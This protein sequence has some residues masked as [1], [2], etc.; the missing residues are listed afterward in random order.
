MLSSTSSSEQAVH[1]GRIS[2]AT[3]GL[4]GLGLLYFLGVECM[5]RFGVPRISRIEKRTALEYD[6]AIDAGGDHTSRKKVLVVGNSLL[7]FGVR[8]DELHVALS[9]YA[10]VRRFVVEQTDFHDWYY[11]VRWLFRAGANPDV[12]VIMLTPKQLIASSIRGDYFAYWMMNLSDCLAVAHDVRL[13]NTQTS[14]LAFAHVSAFFGLRQEIRKVLA[15]KIFPDLPA[16][17]QVLT[18]RGSAPLDED[19]LYSM[20][21]DRLRALRDLASEH[22]TEV[23]LV[24]PPTMGISRQGRIVLR[25]GQV[26][27][28]KVLFPVDSDSLSAS[29]YSD[30][31]HLNEQGAG[32][33]TKRLT[34]CLRQELTDDV[35]K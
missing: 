6:R 11:G 20:A 18:R 12:I 3:W 29:D 10:D 17:M 27:G 23:L 19:L 15:E 35:G 33:F 21:Q 31:F 32:V 7:L 4:I 26:T 14:N 24:M 13:T 30:G 8:F 25:A 2:S 34:E 16:L 1:R 9:P 5:A 28:V 22:G